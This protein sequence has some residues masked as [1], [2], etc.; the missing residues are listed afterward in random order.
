MPVSYGL[1]GPPSTVSSADG[2]NLPVLQGKQGDQIVSELHGKYFTQNYRG[3][4]FYGASAAAGLANSIFSNTAYVGLALWNPTG[5]GK[6]LSVV[7]ASAI[8]QAIGTTALSAFGY[9]VV[10]NAGSA[11]ATGG[12]F[13]AFT[14][15][16]ATRG[17]C[18]SANQGQGNSVALLGSGATLT[19][20]ALWMRNATFGSATGA[21]TVQLATQGTEELDGTLIVPPGMALLFSMSVLSGGTYSSSLIWEEAPL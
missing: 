5:S 19:T 3:N 16:T 14:A 12:P 21:A 2:A 15:I 20:A 13:S 9:A 4:L 17:Q 10:P 1:V 7:R 11:I 18:N 8:M 6:N